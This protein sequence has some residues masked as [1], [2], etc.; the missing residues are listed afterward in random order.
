MNNND[1]SGLPT[2]H[3]AQKQI[4]DLPGRFKIAICGRR[5]GKTVAAAIAAVEKCESAPE[6]NVWWISPVQ[7]QSDR[8]ERQV[9][10]WL[11]GR[12][13]VKDDEEQKV[14][15]TL[16]S[17]QE[18]KR[19]P[20]QYEPRHNWGSSR[21][22]KRG[23][24]GALNLHRESSPVFTNSQLTWE[25][26]KSENALICSNGS[27]IE[28]YS[29]HSGDHLRGAGLDLVVVDEAAYV[30]EDMWSSVLKPM[31][32]D[33]RG[34][35][36]IVGTPR[37]K[38]H[39]LHRLFL[40]GQ[41]GAEGRD[42]GMYASIRFP[43]SANPLVPAGDLKGYK[44]DMSKEK[45]QQ[46]FEAE[47]IDGVD[48]IFPGVCDCI[49]GRL[50][51]KGRPR[52]R[53]ITG[54]DIGVLEDF[55][56]ACSVAIDTD[57]L[58][59]FVRFN[60]VSLFAQAK[61]L[62]EYLKSF[63]GPV[64][65]DRTGLGISVF[66]HLAQHHNAEVRGVHFNA[67]NKWEMLNNL[68]IALEKKLI[69]I[70]NVPQL[71]DELYAFTYLDTPESSMSALGLPRKTGAPSGMHDDCVI[72]LALAWYGL[73]KLQLWGSDQ[74]KTFAPQGLYGGGEMEFQLTGESKMF[75]PAFA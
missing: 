1:A 52:A 43:T 34:E 71:I 51:E 36:Y 33:R 46:E 53:Y 72:A 9:A 39:W 38:N 68:Q 31:L 55:T 44:L 66:Q 54:I 73:K 3:E 14:A 12:R 30:P 10:Y 19:K 74:P 47:F 56:V 25:H 64:V 58:E 69:R 26:K 7:H 23:R 15:A 21:R 57:R 63:P 22:D 49:E 42:C 62:E 45:F 67:D 40:L 75:L 70:P 11:R 48:T 59:G 13:P 50:L 28:F 61:R 65:V 32:L 20:K 6:R 24:N 27:R 41:N 37:G 8:V 17:E 35:A 29:A 4:L 5:F 16:L 2:P 60:R 18:Y